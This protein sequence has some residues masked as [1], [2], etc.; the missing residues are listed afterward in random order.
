[1]TTRAVLSALAL[2]VLAA[3]PGLA[4]QAA[5][6]EADPGVRPTRLLDRAEIRVSRVALQPGATRRV[7]AHDDVK[8]HVWMP[9]TGTM[10]L[11]VGSNAPVAVPVDTPHF[12]ERG[13]MHGFR[14][15]GTAP[16][17][18][19]EIFVKD[20]PSKAGQ[21]PTEAI[22]LAL[23]ALAGDVR[24]HTPRTGTTDPF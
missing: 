14:N 4:Q 20:T 19:L 1:M 23:A 2:A 10:Q 5:P 15:V 12:F 13:T 11:T 16:A 6:G 18:V 9:L 22:A 21:S 24:W 8:F 7:H 3:S 17:A